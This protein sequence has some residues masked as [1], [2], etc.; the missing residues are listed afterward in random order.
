VRG[1]LRL[2]VRQLRA[3]RGVA[4]LLAVVVL[5][6]V[7]LSAAA[8]RLADRAAADDVRAAV[9]ATGAIRRDA[10]GVTDTGPPDPHLPAILPP[11]LAEAAAPLG[12]LAGPPVWSLTMGPLTAPGAPGRENVL[13]ARIG[14]G[15]QE[16][17]RLVEGRLPETAEEAPNPVPP[18]PG[19]PVEAILVLD[20]ALTRTAARAMSVRTGQLVDVAHSSTYFGSPL[21]LHV[22]GL[23][24]PKEPAD[25]FWADGSYPLVPRVT[26]RDPRTTVEGT[27]FAGV[28]ALELLS[29]DV[30]AGPRLALRVPLLPDAVAARPPDEVIAALRRVRAG[31]VPV[32]PQIGGVRLESGLVRV[33]EDEAARRQPLEALTAVLVAVLLAAAVGSILL[34]ARLFVHRRRT[35]LTLARARGASAAQLLA[36]LTA[37]GLLLGVPAAIAG[38][39]LARL[40]PDGGVQGAAGSGRLLLALAVAVTPAAALAAAAARLVGDADPQAGVARRIAARHGANAGLA[41]LVAAAA[42]AAVGLRSRGIDVASAR[43]GESGGDLLVV[44][45][46][47]LLAAAVAVLVARATGP[48]LGLAVRAVA[49]LRGGVAFLGAAR[50][51]R[52]RAAAAVAVVTLALTVAAGLLG[53]VTDATVRDGTTLAASRAT[54]ADL[55]VSGIGFTEADQSALARLPG[56]AVVAAWADPQD[57]GITGANGVTTQTT[58]IATQPDRL[59]A[60]QTDLPLVDGFPAG[61]AGRIAAPAQQA[62]ARGPMP[63]VVSSGLAAVGAPVQLRVAGRPV[64]ATVV[65]TVGSFP[66]APVDDAFVVTDLA[67]LRRRSGL[68]LAP[69]YLLVRTA[70]AGPTDATIRAAVPTLSAT[71]SRQETADRATSSPL[72]RAVRAA[73]PAALATGAGLAALTAVLALLL[74]ARE[75][76]RF[77]AHL[78]ALGL[79]RRQ[80]SAVVALEALPA[81]LAGLVAGLVAGFGLTWLVLPA[82]D[83]RPLAGSSQ[84]LAVVA[85]PAA[86]LTVAG[87]FVLVVVLAVVVAVVAGRSVSPVEAARTVEAP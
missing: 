81:A 1:L 43:P 25:V 60:V 49:P 29:R 65:A 6:T 51:A 37:E 52:E 69:Q 22:V 44:V 47:V 61:A 85:S 18:R 68:V 63:V 62:A 56:V 32:T 53:A 39:L 7:G 50:A 19:E 83:L 67:E 26:F 78:R 24:E 80:S 17:T 28:G 8:L 57:A 84:P 14:S 30:Y 27:V 11:A 2:L 55:R 10:T 20:V 77:I 3:D 15:W 38:L 66:G 79:S 23:L 33:L 34:A 9:A 58:V 48:L 82:A 21:R 35:A 72:V 76:G 36:A 54:A 86:V 16:R 5:A 13:T 87:V 41:L 70:G 45:A 75:R 59:A 71:S 31:L 46:P 12:A 42:L 4:A 73:L 40:V 74:G 64:P